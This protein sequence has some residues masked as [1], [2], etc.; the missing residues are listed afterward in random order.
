MRERIDAATYNDNPFKGSDQPWPIKKMEYIEANNYTKVPHFV[1]EVDPDEWYFIPDDIPKWEIPSTVV[2]E[3]FESELIVDKGY[4]LSLPSAWDEDKIE[5]FFDAPRTKPSR[6]SKKYFSGLPIEFFN[7]EIKVL[8]VE[9]I[10][11]LEKFVNSWGVLYSPFRVA[12]T[13]EL[14]SPKLNELKIVEK[15]LQGIELTNEL[16]CIFPQYTNESFYGEGEVVSLAELQAS[17]LFFQVIVSEIYSAILDGKSIH[18]QLKNEAKA[19]REHSLVGIACPEWGNI[20][21]VLNDSSQ[22]LRRPVYRYMNSVSYSSRDDGLLHRGILSS[23]VAKQLVDTLIDENLWRKCQKTDCDVIFKYQR[24]S[25]RNTGSPH[26]D[27]IYC[28]TSCAATQ[29][30][31]NSRHPNIKH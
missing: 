11:A 10:D 27:A 26:S 15:N 2:G 17:V 20:L 19:D 18:N 1:K 12:G 29:R 16:E 28:S 25:T 9:N 24:S 7:H 6:A 23:A 4:Y 21:A 13:T 5:E 30:K 8:D 31:R 3:G 22:S 14:F